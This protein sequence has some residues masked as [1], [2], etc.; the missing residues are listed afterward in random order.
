MA[1]TVVWATESERPDPMTLA[2]KVPPLLLV[3]ATVCCT[4]RL[5]ATAASAIVLGETLR[6]CAPPLTSRVTVM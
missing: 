4:E 6:S 5:P 2:D 3:T 1:P